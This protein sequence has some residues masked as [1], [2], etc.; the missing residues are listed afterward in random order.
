VTAGWSQS[1]IS[2]RAGIALTRLS[3]REVWI[4]YAVF[5]GELTLD[6]LAERLHGGRPLAA[7]D[8]NVLAAALN[9]HLLD[10]GLHQ[11]VPYTDQLDLGN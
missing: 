8:H 4:S 1:A 11:P 10:L 9:D 7:L 5:G 2:L 6:E 3:Y